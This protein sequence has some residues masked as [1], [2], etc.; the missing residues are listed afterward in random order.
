MTP[1]QASKHTSATTGEINGSE[2]HHRDQGT[3]LRSPLWAFSYKW[4]Y[5]WVRKLEAVRNAQPSD[6]TPCRP[7]T[8]IKDKA[9]TAVH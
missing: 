2:S 8:G 4:P 9:W 3:S 5:A 6:K 7:T 1:F